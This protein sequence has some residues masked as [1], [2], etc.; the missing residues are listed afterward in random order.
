MT[1]LREASRKDWTGKDT[2]QDINAGS[3][4][5]IADAAEKMA[6]R[7]AELIEQ[8]DRYKS[9]YVERGE[10]IARLERRLVAAKGQITK[11]RKQAVSKEPA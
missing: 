7:Y 5:R 11:L 9:M 8:R 3:L 2:L 6:L 1:T 4:Q 10:A